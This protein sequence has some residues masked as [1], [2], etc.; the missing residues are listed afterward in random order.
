MKEAAMDEETRVALEGS[1]EKWRKI[2]AGDG[3]D[4][5]ES[6]CPLCELF[7][8]NFDCAGCPVAEETG[9]GGCRKTPFIEWVNHQAGKHQCRMTPLKIQCPDCT[10]LATA[11]LEFLEGLRP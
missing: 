1:I 3:A 2:A 7:I 6:N 11:E 4:E 9:Q 8:E 5:G 10:A